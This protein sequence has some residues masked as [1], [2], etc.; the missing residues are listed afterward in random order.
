MNKQEFLTRLRKGL[1]GLPSKEKKEH[2]AFYCEMIDDRMEDGLS[3]EAA[4]AEIGNIDEIIAQLKAA[5]PKKKKNAGVIVLLILGLPVWGSLL[6]AAAAVALALYLSLWAV[7][8]SFWAVFAA[9][10]G[11][12]LGGIVG[13]IILFGYGNAPAGLALIG[14]GLVCAGLGIF[15]FYGCKAATVGTLRLTQ[16][17][18]RRVEK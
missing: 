4:V 2:L 13:G 11:S 10:L 6:I 5:T 16:K 12:A 8:I 18:V 17:L 14:A 15:L 7:L 9:L 1:F 3:E